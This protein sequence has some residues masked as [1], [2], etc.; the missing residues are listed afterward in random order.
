MSYATTPVM[1]VDLDATVTGTTTNGEN[2][3]FA[4]GTR[5]VTPDGAEY[6]YVQAGSAITQYHTVAIDENYQAVPITTT[7]NNAG[8]RVG[9]AQV[10]FADNDI[11]W[12]AIN[13]SNIN[14]LVA[15]SCNADVPLFCTATAG[16]LDDAGA[17]TTDKITGIV[18]IAGSTTGTAKAVE[19][20]A[21]WPQ[22]NSPGAGT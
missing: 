15:A 7:L 8:Y 5:I 21:T 12:V 16:V 13:G 20:L 17:T 18:A 10:A 19:V 22:A 3:V 1:G 9:F 4:L 11:G 6:M 14:I 2:R